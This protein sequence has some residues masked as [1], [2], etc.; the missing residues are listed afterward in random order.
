M[1][2]TSTTHKYNKNHHYATHKYNKNSLY[3]TSLYITMQLTSTTRTMHRLTHKTDL[4][5]KP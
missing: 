1:Q 2:L 3:I 5:P 4:N